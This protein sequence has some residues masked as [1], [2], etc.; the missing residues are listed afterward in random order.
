MPFTL[1]QRQQ[2]VLDYLAEHPHAY[3]QDIATHIG[4]TRQRVAQI[5]E[6]L[7]KK[8]HAIDP[9]IARIQDRERQRAAEKKEHQ[10][11]RR[12]EIQSRRSGPHNGR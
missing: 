4:V 8:G 12:A 10:A 5:V 1:T 9:A 6:V 7:N 3:Y 11:Q 2:Q